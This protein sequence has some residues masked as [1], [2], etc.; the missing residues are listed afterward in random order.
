[1]KTPSTVLSRSSPSLRSL[2]FSHAKAVCVICS[3]VCAYVTLMPVR[4]EAKA[5]GS[6]SLPGGPT[7]RFLARGLVA[8][9][10]SCGSAR[11]E[12]RRGGVGARGYQ[13]YG[14]W[15]CS[16][17]HTLTYTCRKAGRAFSF[18]LVIRI[19]TNQ[20]SDSSGSST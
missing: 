18:R 19:K 13:R 15:R 5:C 10:M 3:A 14:G 9:G 11:T 2:H 1:M 12:V 17:K 20:Y 16:E 7:E 8:N 6:V 4:A